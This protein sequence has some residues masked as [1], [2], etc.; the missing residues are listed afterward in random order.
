MPREILVL[1]VI[2]VLGVATAR[3][4]L[5]TYRWEPSQFR[6]GLT[7][8]DRSLPIAAALSQ[9]PA[10][11]SEGHLLLAAS[12]DSRRITDHEVIFLAPYLTWASMR[13]WLRYLPD[14]G[15]I[16][17]QGQLNWAS[18]CLWLCIAFAG[19]R[20]GLGALLFCAWGYVAE[21]VRFRRILREVTD[22]AGRLTTR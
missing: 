4:A 21:Q 3:E 17:I 10:P 5:L 13:G 2:A 1:V 14:E 12:V 18:V 19:S 11:Q 15:R 16:R 20:L 6:A 9:V 7:V 22:Q 8:F